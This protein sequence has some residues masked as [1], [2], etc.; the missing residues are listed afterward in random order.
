MPIRSPCTKSDSDSSPFSKA[1]VASPA[2]RTRNPSRRLAS[3]TMWMISSAFSVA[4][5]IGPFICT[6]MMVVLRSAE[7]SRSSLVR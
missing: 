5:A 3:S 1:M 2:T 7:T 6:E 4:S